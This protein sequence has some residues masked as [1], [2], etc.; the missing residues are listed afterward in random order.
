MYM[1]I[2]SAIMEPELKDIK[3]LAEFKKLTS[4]IYNDV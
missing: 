2:L 4:K 1:F 3:H